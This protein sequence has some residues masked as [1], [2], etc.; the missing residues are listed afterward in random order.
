M[1]R[2]YYLANDLHTCE[3]VER[4]L[5][6][7]GIS[8][9]NFHVVSRDELGLFQHRIH[10]ATTY[11]RLDVVHAGERWGLAGAGLGLLLGLLGLALQPLAW[12]VDG[13]TVFL[14]TLVGALFGAW[15]G[16]LLGLSR[17]CYK[18]ARFSDDLA[19]GRHLLM[20]D[21][22]DDNRSRV[23]ELMSVRFPSVEF[24]GRDTILITPFPSAARA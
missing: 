19:A 4:T 14:T 5:R 9:W 12:P 6:E 8:D 17:D 18:I 22:N 20:V 24:S 21:V 7:A 11:Q 1:P 23:R 13:L 3:V 16:A 10:A 15:R 2:L